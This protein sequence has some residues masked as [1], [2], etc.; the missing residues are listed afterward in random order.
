MVDMLS[1]VAVPEPK[2]KKKTP[3]SVFVV[4]P[5][6]I[7]V[8]AAILMVPLF[9]SGPPIGRELSN[10]SGVGIV[11]RGWG[12]G[13]KTVRTEINS[14]GSSK[15]YRE[16]Y[17]L[18]D[19][20]CDATDGR[21]PVIVKAELPDGKYRVSASTKRGGHERLLEKLCAAYSNAFAVKVSQTEIEMDVYVMTCSDP[22]KLG[23]RK[24]RN[25]EVSFDGDYRG[26]KDQTQF[27]AEF[28]TDMGALAD[29]TG[30]M[31]RKSWA[32]HDGEIRDKVLATVVVDETGLPG[33]YQGKLSWRFYV[34]GALIKELSQKGLKFARAKRKIKAVVIE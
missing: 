24:T 7:V 12:Q 13:Q 17:G 27:D 15:I 16:G 28:T 21:V 25:K 14:S 4:M 33:N 6:L 20:L 1:E 26:S 32:A 18:W 30:Y 23:L 34:N 22:M 8:L 11:R 3:T 10:V 9:R 5:I 2:K 31:I 29:W 19:A